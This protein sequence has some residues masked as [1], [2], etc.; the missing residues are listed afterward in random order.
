MTQDDDATPA[1]Q[2]TSVPPSVPPP[3]TAP[4]QARPPLRRS[5]SDRKIAGVA[6]GLGRYTGVDPIVFRVVLAVLTL[7]GGIGLLIYL[8]A[9]LFLPADGD[10]ASP[11]EAL[12]GRGQSSTSA[13][14]AVLLAVAGVVV[15]CLFVAD[16]PS[17]PLLAL[18]VVGVVLL[19]RH[20]QPG[21]MAVM[22][23]PPGAAT[24]DQP[25]PVQP[26][27]VPPP[28]A[29]HGPYG[30]PFV[31]PPVVP[32]PVKEKKKRSPLGRIVLSAMLLVLGAMAAID[33]IHGVSISGAGYAAAALAVVGAGLVAGAW[34]GRARGLIALGIV[35][36]FV[37]AGAAASPHVRHL[38]GGSG[39]RTWLPTT[40]A[41]VNREYRLGAGNA[42]LDLTH[43]AFT[44]ADV[45][46][47]VRLTVGQVRVLLPAD[48]DAT[49]R[50]STDAG[51]LRVLGKNSD[52]TGLRETVTDLGADGAGGGHLR[53]TIENGLGDVEVTRE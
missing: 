38:G 24:I 11:V 12:L 26:A 10:T 37:L 39:N 43:V 14:N 18:V 46:T 31:P 45:T 30:P 9:W 19:V 48:V 3:P 28:Y 29:P 47:T 8:G 20:R 53:L 1:D 44:D 6:G 41:E 51:N 25:G 7:F 15:A 40:A 35:L 32:P 17:I 13:T 50:A 16:R 27:A 21:G 36:C 22:A 34:F 52:G 49:V 42:T 4:P 33:Q 2:S 5:R 23:G